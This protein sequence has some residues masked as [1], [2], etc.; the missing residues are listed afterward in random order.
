MLT[1]LVAVPWLLSAGL[2]SSGD[3]GTPAALNQRVDGAIITQNRTPESL[4][5][6]TR[7]YN[8]PIVRV[9]TLDGTYNAIVPTASIVSRT[10]TSLSFRRGDGSVK[11]VDNVT[12]EEARGARMTVAL[13]PGVPVPPSLANQAPLHVA[14]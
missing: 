3:T 13:K 12:V 1:M 7:V 9:R 11:T 8:V 4:P 10:A 5:S 6:G 2:Y 14:P